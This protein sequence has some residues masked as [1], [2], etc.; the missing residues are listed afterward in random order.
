MLFNCSDT[1]VLAATSDTPGVVCEVEGR[2]YYSVRYPCGPDKMYNTCGLDAL[3][4]LR[5]PHLQRAVHLYADDTACMLLFP[6]YTGT[7]K[8]LLGKHYSI[9]D[10]LARL[11]P[12]LSALAFL[13]ANK[14]CHGHIGVESVLFR[15]DHVWLCDLA[16]CTRDAGPGFRRDIVDLGHLFARVLHE[17]PAPGNVV[18]HSKATH[19]LNTML[20]SSDTHTAEELCYFPAFDHCRR[21]YCTWREVRPAAPLDRFDED[22][23]QQ[24]KLFLHTCAKNFAQVPLAHLFRAA[25]A[26]KRCQGIASTETLLYTLFYMSLRTCAPL[27]VQEFCAQ[28]DGAV[29]ADDIKHMQLP[30]IRACDGVLWTNHVYDDCLNKDQVERAYFELL[31]AADVSALAS[32]D[33]ELYPHFLGPGVRCLEDWTQGDI[34]DA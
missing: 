18:P 27:D 12:L 21:Q 20:D 34:A 28:A 16:G 10:K 7:I 19:L 2:Y 8:A 32:A 9:A 23:R 25:T 14:V 24:L 1:H 6:V 33:P 11:Y 26:A 17:E 3:C 22:H 29:A 15:G 5:H 31:L 30:I 4:R 13:H